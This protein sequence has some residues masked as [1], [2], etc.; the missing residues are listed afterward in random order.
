MAKGRPQPP[1]GVRS[2]N[3][4]LVGDPATAR[5]IAPVVDDV[6]EL[7]RRGAAV[8]VDGSAPPE[9]GGDAVGDLWY[10]GRDGK[11]ARLPVGTAGQVLTVVD[12]LPRW[13]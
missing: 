5:A 13:V 7:Q 6:R 3:A 1:R 8:L 10:R 2:A 4:P 11:L 9:L 12:G